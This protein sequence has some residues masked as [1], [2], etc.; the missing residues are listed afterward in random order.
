MTT[1]TSDDYDPVH[2]ALQQEWRSIDKG[3]DEAEIRSKRLSQ[4]HYQTNQVLGRLRAKKRELQQ[5]G[6]DHGLK[7]FEHPPKS[8]NT[9]SPDP[10]ERESPF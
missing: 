6:L 4:E 9:C 1:V 10:F 3:I 7:P 8:M 5:F 2:Y